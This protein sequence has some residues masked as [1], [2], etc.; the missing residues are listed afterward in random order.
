MCSIIVWIKIL[1]S[2]LMNLFVYLF[3]PTYIPFGIEIHLVI[4]FPFKARP[5]SHASWGPRLVLHS[6][7]L[8]G[9][10]MV[11]HGREE[12]LSLSRPRLS[13]FPPSPSSLLLLHACIDLYACWIFYKKFTIGVHINMRSP[14][15]SQN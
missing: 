11:F 9:V 12:P 4:G 3:V 15:K 6:H 14:I 2:K 1:N 8:K 5:Y 10:P 7:G 13:Q